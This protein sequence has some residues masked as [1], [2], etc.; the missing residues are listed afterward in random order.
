MKGNTSLYNSVTNAIGY[1][2]NS[3]LNMKIPSSQGQRFT[4]L[5]IIFPFNGW[6]GVGASH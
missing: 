4:R 3:T 5:C 6:K 2:W 1:K